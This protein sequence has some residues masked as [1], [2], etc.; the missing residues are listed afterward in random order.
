M[1]VRSFFGRCWSLQLRCLNELSKLTGKSEAARK[2]LLQ[3][4]SEVLKHEAVA[5]LVAD[6]DVLTL[7]TLTGDEDLLA[8]ETSV[9][10]VQSRS[11]GGQGAT[12]SQSGSQHQTSQS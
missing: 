8:R 6:N 3:E 2:K 5:C 11:S 12:S 4:N 7:G 1:V 10:C 9:L